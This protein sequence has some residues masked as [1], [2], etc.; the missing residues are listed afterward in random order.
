MTSGDALLAALDGRVKRDVVGIEGF[1]GCVAFGVRKQNGQSLW[2]SAAFDGGV[3]TSISDAVPKFDA[4]V[5]LA[6]EAAI[7]LLEGRAI[8]S[9]VVC[10][11]TG[12]QDLL[13]R[14]LER[15]F[16]PMS[17]VS[18]RARRVRRR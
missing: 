12:D 10:I 2:W 17:L 4:A 18:V 14:F 11:R 7:A 9:N 3:T 6:E 15:Y 8:P 13:D 16:R 5:G 1:A